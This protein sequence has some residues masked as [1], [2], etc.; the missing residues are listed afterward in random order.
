MH[1]VERLGVTFLPESSLQPL[2]GISPCIMKICGKRKRKNHH[3]R[4]LLPWPVGS[5]LGSSSAW[6]MSSAGT[7]EKSSSSSLQTP[8]S[9]KLFT[10]S[11]SLTFGHVLLFSSQR[12]GRKPKFSYFVSRNSQPLHN[13]SSKFLSDILVMPSPNHS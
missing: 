13:S 10:I 2:L 8:M 1:H 4:V 5:H 3:G 12:E 9:L 11:V 6:F 7:F